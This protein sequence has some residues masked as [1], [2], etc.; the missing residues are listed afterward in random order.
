[1]DEILFEMSNLRKSKYKA[2]PV[3]IWISTDLSVRHREPTIKFQNNY[4][5]RTT[6]KS[7]LIPMSIIDGR[8]LVSK[9][10]DISPSDLARVRKFVE[11]NRYLLIKLW[12]QDIDDED[13]RSGADFDF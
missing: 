9:K 2:L 12:N 11:L 5:D 8:I 1:M 10:V 13:F 3:N 4:S 6:S 7:D